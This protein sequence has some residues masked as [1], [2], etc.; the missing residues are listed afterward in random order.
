MS[1]TTQSTTSS[2]PRRRTTDVP[3]TP[4]VL[5]ISHGAAPAG[6]ADPAGQSGQPQAAAARPG[7]A[8]NPYPTHGGGYDRGGYYG[9]YYGSALPPIPPPPSPAYAIPAARAPASSY[10]TAARAAAAVDSTRIATEVAD[11]LK[12]TI[13]AAQS[14]SEQAAA[15]AVEALAGG[16]GRSQ[17]CR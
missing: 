11:V 3:P 16:K 12:P 7:E 1:T 10:D 5:R 13:A 8:G 4:S 9:S 2:D 17:R 14:R 6:G 15:S